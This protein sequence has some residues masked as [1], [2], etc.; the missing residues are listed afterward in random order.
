MLELA[1]LRPSRHIIKPMQQQVADTLLCLSEQAKAATIPFHKSREKWEVIEQD[2]LRVNL[3]PYFGRL[4]TE[5]I[6]EIVDLCQQYIVGYKLVNRFT[7]YVNSDGRRGLYC[8]NMPVL[9]HT[10]RIFR[11]F[12][13][14]SLFHQGLI[15]CEHR[16]VNHTV[17][18]LARMYPSTRNRVWRLTLKYRR[19]TPIDYAAFRQLCAIISSMKSLRD[20]H[21]DLP[22]NK[23]EKLWD[24]D[25]WR[26]NLKYSIEVARGIGW[27]NS[28]RAEWVRHLLAVEAVADRGFEQVDF[29]S[30]SHSQDTPSTKELREWIT[31]TMKKDLKT[32]RAIAAQLEQD[33]S[34]ASLLSLK[35]LLTAI[36]EIRI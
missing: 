35:G 4:P 34:W 24:P 33:T 16:D 5:I 17:Q 13:M 30:Y 25:T 18:V 26:A 19:H 1:K 9:S 11:C 27:K 8:Y 22:L 12:A 21:F 6:L 2:P 10:S 28:Q 15:H 20:L 36:R 14:R 29:C 23:E 7:Y 31:K 32:R 3:G